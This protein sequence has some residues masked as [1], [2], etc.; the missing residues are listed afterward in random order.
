M[1]LFQKLN[2]VRTTTLKLTNKGAH[3]GFFFKGS[4]KN[5]SRGNYKNYLKIKKNVK[6]PWQRQGWSSFCLVVVFFLLF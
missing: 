4:E 6:F 3:G 5:F 2:D 1:I